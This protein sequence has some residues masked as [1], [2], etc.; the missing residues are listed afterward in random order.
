[1]GSHPF[2]PHVTIASGAG[3]W[4]E[5]A[6]ADVAAET[7]AFSAVF[8]RVE[9]SEIFFEAVVLR[10]ADTEVF[11]ALRR[12]IG[13]ALGIDTASRYRPHLSIAYGDLDADVRSRVAES[14]R[15]RLPLTVPF[16]RLCLVDTSDHVRFDWPVLARW[17]LRG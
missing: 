11:A 1:M 13:G 10:P 9:G 14:L 17:F 15:S 6:A 8:D 5:S 2:A 7:P 16:G 12:G 4:D 3:G